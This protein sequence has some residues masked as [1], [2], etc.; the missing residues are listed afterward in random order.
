MDILYGFYKLYSIVAEWQMFYKGVIETKLLFQL[1]LYT[2]NYIYLR[3]K[4]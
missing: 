3:E 2:S 4:N 1:S